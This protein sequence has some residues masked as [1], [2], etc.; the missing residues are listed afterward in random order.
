[1]D[2]RIPDFF[3]VG[4]P[5][6]G[7][8]ALYAMLRR[9]PGIFMPDLKEPRFFDDQRPRPR[10]HRPAFPETLEEYSALFAPASPDQ[11]AGEAS[12]SYLRSQGAARRIAEL[13]PDAKCIAILREPTSFL[14]SYHLHLRR[15]HAEPARTLRD[16]VSAEDEEYSN[17]VRYV[18]HLRRL[19]DVFPREQ[20]LILIHEEFRRDN[21]GTVRQAFRFLGVDDS[22][23][24]TPL[25]ANTGTRVRSL[26]LDDVVTSMYM[27]HGP[28]SGR[29]RRVGKAILPERLNR[30][31]NRIRLA[32]VYGKPEAPD[33]ELTAE[34]RARYRP[35]VEALSEYLGRDLV[36]FWGYG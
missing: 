4:F 2:G 12:P 28:I 6:C 24:V 31:P 8:T 13:R 9:H 22:V 23:P 11:I 27:G 5:K 1:M 15:H 34:L 36:S 3:I 35:E 19:H 20:T 17:R 7:T 26:R 29:V 18:E 33:E 32:I 25:E 30:V 14:R 10:P 16:A 21:E